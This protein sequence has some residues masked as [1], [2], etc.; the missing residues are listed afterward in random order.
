MKNLCKTWSVMI[1]GML[2]LSAGCSVG[3][4]LVEPARYTLPASS[5]MQVRLVT[6]VTSDSASV[7]QPVSGEVVSDIATAG[8][9]VIPTG[10]QVTGTV[11]AVRPAKRFGGQAMVSV[12]FDTVSTPSGDTVAVEGSMAAYADK[13]KGKDTGA[14]VGGTLGGALLGRVIGKDT[15]GAVAG[16]VV[17]GGVGTAIA[18]R[19]GD[20]AH[21][22]AGT[23][24]KVR[25]TRA[26]DLPEA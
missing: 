4:K 18:S 25:T 1:L 13:T 22:P 2:A 7:G 6:S 20:E 15:K 9:V 12:N 3:S 10:S 16:A 26:L 11:T 17:G 19:K 8:H 24:A 23:S 5:V 21:L 14:I